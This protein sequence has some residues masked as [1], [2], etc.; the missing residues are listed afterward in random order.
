VNRGL[1]RSDEAHSRAKEWC[2]DATDVHKTRARG[3]R[4]GDFRLHRDLNGRAFRIGRGDR[5]VF[6]ALGGAVAGANNSDYLRFPNG[7]SHARS[8][9]ETIAAATVARNDNAEGCNDRAPHTSAS[10]H[11]R[12]DGR[13]TATDGS[14]GSARLTAARGDATNTRRH[15]ITNAD[16]RRD[17]S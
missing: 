7:A 16:F 8:N 9:T 5:V 11:S 2:C 6:A 12:V 4:D 15:G 17:A 3:N 14:A 1:L 10:A 13:S